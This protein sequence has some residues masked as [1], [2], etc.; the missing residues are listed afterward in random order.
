MIIEFL[1]VFWL[2]SEL[3]CRG[4]IDN[5]FCIFK[6]NTYTMSFLAKTDMVKDAPR[7]F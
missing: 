7:W 3:L 6:K 4:L 1:I 2:D 5:L